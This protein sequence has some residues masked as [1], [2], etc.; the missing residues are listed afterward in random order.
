M[1]TGDSLPVSPVTALA[2]WI[3]LAILVQRVAGLEL[4]ALGAATMVLALAGAAPRFM[5][6][7]VR[8]RWLFLS[9]LLIYALATPGQPLADAVPL[10]SMTAEGVAGGAQQAL[11][12]A[13]LLASLALLLQGLSREQLLA[14]IY[15]LLRPLRLAGI[16]PERFA[17]R[18]GLTLS[19]ADALPPAKLGRQGWQALAG[20]HRAAT[21]APAT[22][23]L[24][25]RQDFGWRDALALA[26]VAGLGGLL[27][28]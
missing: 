7:V 19:Y 4:V 23:L 27:L 1:N 17:V 8:A 15:G 25:P 11:R 28:A 24:L 16:N 14:G 18:L 12:L 2:C 20:S 9:L 5:R 22:P 3:A 13:V 21:P 6:L 10:S 26:V